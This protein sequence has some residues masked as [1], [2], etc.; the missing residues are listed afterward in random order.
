MKVDELRDVVIEM[1][2]M[3]KSDRYISKR[4]GLELGEVREIR[5]S[6]GY[7]ERMSE[8]SIELVGGVVGG[9]NLFRRLVD[10]MLRG[11]L[12]GVERRY[13]FELLV[14]Y[15]GFGDLM[16]GV[17]MG[18]GSVVGV[19][20]EERLMELGLGVGGVYEMS[21]VGVKEGGVDG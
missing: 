14:R 18:E 17:L 19:S 13:V 11:G 16:R 7:I 9:V 2:L 4:L 21:G 12:V 15:C 1:M 6:R 3:G 8:L 5:N 20:K 10:E